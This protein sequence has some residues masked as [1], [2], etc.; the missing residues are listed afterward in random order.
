MEGLRAF[1]I[2]D[3]ANPQLSGFYDDGD[4]HAK[5]LVC[6]GDTIYVGSSNGLLV[7]RFDGDT[8]IDP[9]ANAGPATI[10]L[11]QNT[12]NPFN[13]STVIE[14]SLPTPQAVTLRVFDLAGRLVRELVNGPRAAGPH[15]VVFDGRGLASGV[16]VYELRAG[17]TSTSRKMLLIQ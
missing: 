13:P 5:A 12:P 16:Y 3:P 8:A 14:Y 15:Q 10:A 1:D 6:R 4:R 2:S 11:A 17:Q 9:P 7:V